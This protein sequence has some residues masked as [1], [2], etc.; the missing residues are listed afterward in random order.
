MAIHKYKDFVKIIFDKVS[1][2]WKAYIIEYNV[3]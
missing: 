3:I 1:Y 2:I